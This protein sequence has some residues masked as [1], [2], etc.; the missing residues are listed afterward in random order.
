M[1]T[2]PFADGEIEVQAPVGASLFEVA[3]LPERHTEPHQILSDALEA[4]H[5][6]QALTELL[7]P[8]ADR[9]TVIV[10]NDATRPTPTGLVL[11]TLIQR[12]LLRATAT[13][14]GRLRLLIAT[15][16]HAAGG[17]DELAQIL[18]DKNVDL[19]APLVRWHD[20]RDAASSV[21]L[22]DTPVHTP[23]WINREVVEADGLILINSVEPHY[24]AGYTGGRKS[25]VP[26]VSGFATIEANHRLAL[27]P[28]AE[29]LGLDGN[30]VHEDLMEAAALLPPRPLLSI[31]TVLDRTH[32]I[33]AAYAG[34][35]LETFTDAVQAANREYVVDL[36]H[37]YDIV[38]TAAAPPM[39]YDLYQSH[40]A[41]ENASLAVR[42]GGAL[43]LVSSCRHGI[44]DRTFFDL[45]AA[46]SDPE[47]VLKAVAA[48]YRLGFHKAARL[49][50][51]A[52]RHR[53]MSVTGL[54]QDTSR[55]AFLE[56]FPSLTAALNDAA[57]RLGPN[58]SILVIPD[59]C[60]TVPRV[61]ETT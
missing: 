43:V 37:R 55:A 16:A 36:P 8:R 15:G 25:L 56:P 38:V 21:Y 54:S 29:T 50:S 9:R 7:A 34:D 10:V 49:A 13:V 60:V 28:T 61:K 23:V 12:G 35:L 52:Q 24:F 19:L 27:D 4:P 58:P 5:V 59:G 2:I 47:S 57:T 32:N 18:G 44:G 17:P 14:T 20:A 31:Q 33:C 48:T 30:P 26:G 22:G 3:P 40:K 46:S 41:L 53:I 45:L 11:D 1:L 39:D 51:L 6:H 42:P